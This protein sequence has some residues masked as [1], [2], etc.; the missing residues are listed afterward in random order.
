M[1]TAPRG[2]RAFCTP[3]AAKDD[4]A[5]FGVPRALPRA[6]IAANSAVATL[7]HESRGVPGFAL[8]RDVI[9]LAREEEL[10]RVIGSQTW[11]GTSLKRRVQHYGFQYDYS[12]R[13]PPTPLQALPRWATE[14][15]DDVV[16]A[17]A[18]APSVPNQVIVNEYAA[19]QG[20]GAHTDHEAFFG[21]TIVAVSLGS[22]T[23]LV[24]RPKRGGGGGGGG[25]TVLV[26]RR[27]A[28]RLQGAARYEW[29]HEI[30]AR[31]SDVWP[32]VG[33][34]RRGTRVSV[35]FRTVQ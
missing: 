20:I 4:A 9:S 28:Y 21:D 23:A 27:S 11:D 6:A 33:T 7:V 16:D 12:A 34:A 29:T 13:R 18:G 10:L 26:P 5:A 31:A 35:T 3:A 30:P 22:P 24:L 1:A 32:G 8:V 14:L 17:G 19:G 25:V 15:Y 2:L